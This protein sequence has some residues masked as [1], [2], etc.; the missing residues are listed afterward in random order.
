MAWQ[1]A[2]LHES[3]YTSFLVMGNGWT[4]VQATSAWSTWKWVHRDTHVLAHTHTH[5]HIHIQAQ[6]P[7]F[8]PSQLR[9]SHLPLF[10]LQFPNSF[11]DSPPPRT[12]RSNPMPWGCS[13]SRRRAKKH[14]SST[15]YGQKTRCISGPRVRRPMAAYSSGT[16]APT[17]V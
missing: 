3:K 15:K 1:P 5:T 17:F 7:S 12:S 9:S 14:C 11:L 4:R 8:F 16:L 10:L 2:Q 13:F 6:N